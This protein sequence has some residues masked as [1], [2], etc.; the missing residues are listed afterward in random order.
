L[1]GKVEK[2]CQK[3]PKKAQGAKKKA[4]L[5]G[6]FTEKKRGGTL[7]LSIRNVFL[8]VLPLNDNILRILSR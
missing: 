5:L 7:Y 4:V 8:K 6:I 3:D 2:T 1:Y